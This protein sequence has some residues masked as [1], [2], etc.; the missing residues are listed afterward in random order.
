MTP[1]S[2]YPVV[3][4]PFNVGDTFDC[5][6]SG[7]RPR[8]SCAGGSP[9]ITDNAQAGVCPHHRQL[10]SAVSA[11][12]AHRGKIVTDLSRTYLL[13]NHRQVWSGCHLQGH[14]C[15][16]TRIAAPDAAADDVMYCRP[17]L[18]V[19]RAVHGSGLGRR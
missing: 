14:M 4:P 12:A 1:F 8:S 18:D 9:G 19:C 15:C 6:I 5:K 16:V 17:H 7:K 11:A 13:T 3:P 10:E 2:P